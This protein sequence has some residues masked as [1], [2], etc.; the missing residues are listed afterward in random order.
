MYS[1]TQVITGMAILLSGYIQLFTTPGI[2]SYH[3]QT[4]V[5]LAWFSSLSHLSTLTA[6]RD[7]FRLRPKMAAYR[8]I[9]MGVVL[10]LLGTALGPTGYISQADTP[11]IPAS[12]LFSRTAHED[13]KTAIDTADRHGCPRLRDGIIPYDTPLILI[14][15]AFLVFSYVTRV[16]RIF[17]PA[18]KF[19]Q[20]WLRVKPRKVFRWLYTPVTEKLGSSPRARWMSVPRWLLKLI[21]V[22]MRLAYEIHGSMLWEV[23]VNVLSTLHCQFW[24][25]GI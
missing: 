24:S 13:V 7:Y 8:A 10:V 21:Y 9:F 17:A 3:W 20:E 23:S 15:L 19:A 22:L 14:S 16:I 5:N 12:C 18:S 2:S 11:S 1:D 6:L 4:I 25:L